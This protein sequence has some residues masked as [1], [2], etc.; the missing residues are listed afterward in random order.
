MVLR[1]D[2]HMKVGTYESR[3]LTA[4]SSKNRV[5]F[6]TQGKW[7]R[8]LDEDQGNNLSS[9]QSLVHIQK[10]LFPQFAMVPP[11]VILFRNGN[12]NFG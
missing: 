11:S 9:S 2:S 7:F 12:G 5:C 4:K 10:D 1:A 6:H 3:V 8:L